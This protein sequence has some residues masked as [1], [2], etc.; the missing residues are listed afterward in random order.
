MRLFTSDNLLMGARN[1]PAVSWTFCVTNA[2]ESGRIIDLFPALLYSGANGIKV[3]KNIRAVDNDNTVVLGSAADGFNPTFDGGKGLPEYGYTHIA[4][5]NF[6]VPN[7][8]C[9]VIDVKTDLEQY[10]V[11]G[12]LATGQVGIF[13][14]LASNTNTPGQDPSVI[15]V[16]ARTGKPMK[17][18]IKDSVPGLPIGAYGSAMVAYQNKLTTSWAADSPQGPSSGTLTQVIGKLVVTNLVNSAA[19]ASSTNRITVD[20][21]SEVV[22]TQ[23]RILSIYRDSLAGMPLATHTFKTGDKISGSFLL[24]FADVAL[25]SGSTK[26]F[27]I[28]LDTPDFHKPLDIRVP[29][30]GIAWTDGIQPNGSIVAMGFDLPLAYRRLTY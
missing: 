30:D 29:K 3:Y 21:L 6:V 5:L 28:T 10:G 7:D 25:A 11:N 14:L 9:G 2:T 17:V 18:V 23:S 8:H 13:A 26:T 15:A 24:F 4:N 1:Q 16:T 22:A 12:I 20:L 19:A 27:L